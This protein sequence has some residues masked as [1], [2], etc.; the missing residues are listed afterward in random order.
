MTAGILA[1]EKSVFLLQKLMLDLPSEA[2]KRHFIPI[3]SQNVQFMFNQKKKKVSIPH[4]GVLVEVYQ[5]CL[6]KS[7]FEVNKTMPDGFS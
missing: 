5:T 1:H 7:W 3:H 6:K 2:K 4:F